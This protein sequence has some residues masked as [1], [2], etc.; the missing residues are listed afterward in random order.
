MTIHRLE[1]F[2]PKSQHS[3]LNFERGVETNSIEAQVLKACEDEMAMKTKVWF[4]KEGRG[5]YERPSDSGKEIT[6]LAFVSAWWMSS[7]LNETQAKL[8]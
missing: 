1:P 2:P 5:S 8:F 7:P 4:G 3:K 6:S